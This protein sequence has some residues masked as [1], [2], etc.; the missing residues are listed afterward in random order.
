M[1]Q[2]APFT[3]TLTPSRCDE[4]ERGALTRLGGAPPLLRRMIVI[5]AR[6]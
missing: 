4:L 3:A 6:V 1:A 5:A 2:L